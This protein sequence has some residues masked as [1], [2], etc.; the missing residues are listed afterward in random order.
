MSR[1][2]SRRDVYWLDMGSGMLLAFAATAVPIALLSGTAP[3]IG[4]AM[5]VGQAAVLVGALGAVTA[6][7]R[8]AKRSPHVRRWGAVCSAL[9]AIATASAALLSGTVITDV[10]RGL[11][12]LLFCTVPC[13]LAG[14]GL[15]AI[16]HENGTR[17]GKFTA[18]YVLGAVAAG[19][20]VAFYREAA[21]PAIACAA[22]MAAVLLSVRWR[23]TAVTRLS[24]PLLALCIAWFATGPE[25]LGARV[26]VE[27]WGHVDNMGWPVAKIV[28][29]GSAF[30]AVIA[31]LSLIGRAGE[32]QRAGLARL[33]LIALFW[34]AALVALLWGALHAG[35]EARSGV[36]GMPPWLW[37]GLGAVAGGLVVDSWPTG[38][39]GLRRA[40]GG[41]AFGVVAGSALALG[42][43]EWSALAS[44]REVVLTSLLFL[45]GLLLSMVI[46]AAAR[47]AINAGP[48]QGVWL[49]ASAGLVMVS[50]STFASTLPLGT[51]AS[52]PT[53]A[54]GVCLALVPYLAVAE[55]NVALGSVAGVMLRLGRTTPAQVRQAQERSHF[56]HSLLMRVLKAGTY[57]GYVPWWILL[58][59]I[60]IGWHTTR[61]VFVMGY[62]FVGDA[63]GG[64]LE[65][66]FGGVPSSSAQQLTLRERAP[67]V[68]LAPV[69]KWQASRGATHPGREQRRGILVGEILALPFLALMMAMEQTLRLGGAT[70]RWLA[71][72]RDPPRRPA[73]PHSEEAALI[74]TIVVDPT[75][76]VVPG[77]T[78]TPEAIQK[79]VLRRRRQDSIWRR[80]LRLILGNLLGAG[81]SKWL[82]ADAAVPWDDRV[83]RMEVIG[84]R[85]RRFELLG[86]L[87]ASNRRCGCV[88]TVPTL[89]ANVEKAIEVGVTHKEIRA[90]LNNDPAQLKKMLLRAAFDMAVLDLNK[91]IAG[92][93][94]VICQSAREDLLEPHQDRTCDLR[95]ELPGGS[96]RCR[97][98][99][100]QDAARGSTTLSA[101]SE[102]N[103][104]EI[105]ERCSNL[106]LQGTIGV[107]GEEG[108]LH[109]RA[110][111]LCRLT[112]KT[113]DTDECQRLEC[114]SP[115]LVTRVVAVDAR[116]TR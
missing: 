61:S 2:P 73:D 10:N 31:P 103:F 84:P 18:A 78:T 9:F 52:I 81:L 47:V 88:V 90:L 16:L 114:F 26:P 15:A 58:G 80:W 66:V 4:T 62:D 13:L 42:V 24:V 91:G 51:V 21:A 75:P 36:S 71:R 92:S 49:W 102:C 14:V 1:H 34:P 77:P 3:G 79:A 72:R 60:S 12:A 116:R 28:I 68:P 63:V 25:L 20:G 53:V 95:Q 11:A 112:R 65:L 105:W 59:L 83:F 85:G 70:V 94:T 98:P 109:R 56:R 76:D 38:I 19:T 86:N 41:G 46:P 100:Q 101:C 37:M 44:A 35:V 74:E 96:Y 50:A 39:T 30:A 67:I 108:R 64:P 93:R 5:S 115:S 55:V 57:V 107:I 99:L 45:A 33:H 48:A 104:P 22:A 40:L 27:L 29:W 17:C 32:E 7:R 69:E 97:R 87:W 8:T 54:L 110:H 43:A 23:E 82:A 106:D 113:P 89:A 111:V 6:W